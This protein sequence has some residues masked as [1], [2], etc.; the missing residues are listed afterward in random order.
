MGARIRVGLV[1]VCAIV[2]LSSC[3]HAP[4]PEPG[5]PVS[6][7]P[8][9]SGASLQA[10]RVSGRIP[11]GFD[12]TAVVRCDLARRHRA[13]GSDW[14]YVVERRGST[15]V[16]DLV[17]ALRRPSARP[18]G[19]CAAIG[20]IDPYVLLVD[21]DE[22]AIVA[23]FPRDQCGAPQRAAVEALAAIPMRTVTSLSVKQ[24]SSALAG[25]TGCADQWKDVLALEGRRAS[26]S[27]VPPPAQAKLRL[28]VY[29]TAPTVVPL[30][31]PTAA[32]EVTVGRLVRG[33]RLNPV[34]SARIL[35]TL[36]T[37][38]VAQPCQLPHQEF[39]V[40]TAAT[41][42]PVYVEVDGCQRFASPTGDLRSVAP[43]LA[44]V[45]VS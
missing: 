10:P 19:D 16:T 44:A 23:A 36:D 13:D 8:H 42:G 28:C 32:T 1:T 29:R 33:R 27:D 11:A 45:L 37:S 35:A 41:I 25:R 6:S 43:A 14:D 38:H 39:A 5:P 21:A 30:G 34:E 4:R 22:Q 17:A 31:D 3:L 15:G 20:Y 26:R 24:V 9:C 18:G 7:A 12:A 40:L 2:A